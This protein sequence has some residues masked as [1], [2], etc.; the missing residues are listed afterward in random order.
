MRTRLGA[1]STE[2][3]IVR[4]RHS[5]VIPIAPSSTMK[6]VTEELV[7]SAWGES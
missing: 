4:W 2:P 5:P 6:Y 3:V 7:N 1:A